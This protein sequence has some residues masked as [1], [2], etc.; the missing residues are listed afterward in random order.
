MKTGSQI[1]GPVAI[2]NAYNVS[3]PLGVTPLAQIAVY[4]SDPAFQ[5][6]SSGTVEAEAFP[7]RV[8]A[9]GPQPFDTSG[10]IGTLLDSQ[11]VRITATG[12]S[13]FTMPAN[14]WDGMEVDV[15]NANTFAPGTSATVTITGNTGQT[16]EL[17]DQPGV[18]AASTKLIE[19][20]GSV[21]FRFDQTLNAW[22]IHARSIP[23]ARLIY[24]TAG[25]TVTLTGAATVLQQTG[26]SPSR[27]NLPATP[28]GG[29]VVRV[30]DISGNGLAQKIQVFTGIAA[31]SIEG[32]I[33][34]G[35]QTG[36]TG[37]DDIATNWQGVTWVFD[38]AFMT[39][40][41]IG[42]LL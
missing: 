34:G 9:V 6:P 32:H 7:G 31:D 22:I 37:H 35:V 36:P 18:R 25:G 41:A 28:P 14:P 33:G 16:V 27:I 4:G 8:V 23:T 2:A 26:G 3:G 29:T 15:K 39:W 11:S 10:A 1:I 12:A 17:I 40:W 5:Q 24:G 30:K 13:G 19:P 20:G 38:D 42:K 21:R